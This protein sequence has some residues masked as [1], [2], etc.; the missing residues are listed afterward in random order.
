MSII[1]KGIDL[2]ENF[3]AVAIITKNTTKGEPC[4]NAVASYYGSKNIIQIPKGVRLVDANELSKEV[5][6]EIEDFLTESGIRS[7]IRNAPTILEEEEEEVPFKEVVKDYISA[8][9]GDISNL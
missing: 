3:E 6:I 9:Y 5:E 7:V 2:P 1:L 8:T 4:Y